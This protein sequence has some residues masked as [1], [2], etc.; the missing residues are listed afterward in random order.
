MLKLMVNTNSKDESKYDDSTGVQQ[1]DKQVV[2]QEDDAK[3]A[4]DDDE[5]KDVITDEPFV[6]QHSKTD[7][8]QGNNSNNNGNT[9]HA[10]SDETSDE[11]RN[12]AQ[13]STLTA[14]DDNPAEESQQAAELVKPVKPLAAWL[15]HIAFAPQLKFTRSGYTQT[16]LL[17]SYTDKDSSDPTLKHLRDKYQFA[18]APQ[19]KAE[20][21][22]RVL[23]ALHYH[24]AIVYGERV[25]DSRRP[26]LQQISKFG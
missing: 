26:L 19:L 10:K 18:C 12:S 24:G 4:L 21:G 11:N 5:K 17:N 7:S 22:F 20:D 14:T 23:T 1:Q 6:V 9:D 8:N 13:D 16:I 3:Y 15:D 2:N 25:V